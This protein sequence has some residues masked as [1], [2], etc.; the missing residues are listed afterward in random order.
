MREKIDKLK[1]EGLNNFTES[2]GGNIVLTTPDQ[3]KINLFK[4]G[5]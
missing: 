4:M 3:Q 2:G 1:K 5:I